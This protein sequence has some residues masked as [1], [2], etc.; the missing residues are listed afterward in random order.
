MWTCNSGCLI[1]K[2]LKLATHYTICM[3][4]SWT[5]ILGSSGGSI[6][7]YN[8]VG[9]SNS[10]DSQ[11]ARSSRMFYWDIRILRWPSLLHQHGAQN[12]S[13]AQQ[14]GICHEDPPRDGKDFPDSR[15]RFLSHKA[16]DNLVLGDRWTGLSIDNRMLH[17]TLEVWSENWQMELKRFRTRKQKKTVWT[18]EFES[19]T[20]KS[21]ISLVEG[22]PCPGL[23]PGTSNNMSVPET[24]YEGLT[25]CFYICIVKET[26]AGSLR[27]LYTLFQSKLLSSNSMAIGQIQIICI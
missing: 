4:F 1:L 6:E 27:F 25:N 8:S 2:S 20:S 7:S 24:I 21:A 12:F 15:A 19:E 14:V 9:L 13:P 26:G 3:P 23:D 10:G 11:I 17:C 18:T 5:T 22:T 16:R